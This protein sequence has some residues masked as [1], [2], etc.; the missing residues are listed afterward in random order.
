MRQAHQ[1]ERT[2]AYLENPAFDHDLHPVWRDT[3]E[4]VD[5]V[6][7]ERRGLIGVELHIMDLAS[8]LDF[9]GE[10]SHGGAEE[11]SGGECGLECESVDA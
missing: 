6:L 3:C 11:R 9:D 8:V 10:G 5:R 2:D 4:L 7:E 1:E